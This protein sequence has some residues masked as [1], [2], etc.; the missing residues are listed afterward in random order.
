MFCD[1][2][3]YLAFVVVCKR[4]KRETGQILHPDNQSRKT[5]S[6]R[7]E[8]YNPASLSKASKP[9]N[10]HLPTKDVKKLY[11]GNQSIKEAQTD[12]EE[13]SKDECQ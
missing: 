6:Q 7:L 10:I 11:R 12:W 9:Y 8:K 2:C 4:F 5:G 13:K 3:H 1:E